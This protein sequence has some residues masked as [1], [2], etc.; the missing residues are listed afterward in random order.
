MF[1]FFLLDITG[2]KATTEEKQGSDS[3]EEHGRSQHPHFCS[4]LTV[5]IQPLAVKGAQWKPEQLGKPSLTLKDT[6]EGC[7]CHTH[8]FKFAF[9]NLFDGNDDNELSLPNNILRRTL[10]D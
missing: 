1:F 7:T 3:T 5:Y 4:G 10:L 9:Y 8:L 6:G 2:P